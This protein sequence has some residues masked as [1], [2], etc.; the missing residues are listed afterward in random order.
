MD[1]HRIRQ[2]DERA[3]FLRELRES[4]SDKEYPYCEASLVYDLIT[5]MSVVDDAREE[6]LDEYAEEVESIVSGVLSPLD[7]Y[8]DSG[9][10]KNSL[11]T[12]D[13]AASMCV[14]FW[15]ETI[16]ELRDFDGETVRIGS[17]INR[18]IHSDDQDDVVRKFEAIESAVRE[19]L[20]GMTVESSFEEDSPYREVLDDVE[21]SL[22]DMVCYYTLMM[23]FH[24][25]FNGNRLPE[26]MMQVP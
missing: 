10:D 1:R 18:S 24:R 26:R 23:S 17:L 16:G 4:V 19:N 7:E 15:Y 20:S 22:E 13:K 12:E 8:V 25:V 9:G 5:A 6:G 14:H 3:K 11:T 2:K 21:C